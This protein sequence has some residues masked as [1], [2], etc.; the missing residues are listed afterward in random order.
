MFSFL[1]PHLTLVT[2]HVE[3]DQEPVLI[4][5]AQ[6]KFNSAEDMVCDEI[7]EASAE[8]K[9]PV[10]LQGITVILHSETDDIDATIKLAMELRATGTKEAANHPWGQ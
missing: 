7:E 1:N 6:W 2:P 10:A 9:P 5:H 4:L 3:D 8:V